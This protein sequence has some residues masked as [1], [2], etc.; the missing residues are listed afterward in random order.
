MQVK[1]KAWGDQVA[2]GLSCYR[3]G[4]VC[5]DCGVTWLLLRTLDDTREVKSY[6]RRLKH[7]H[8][9]PKT[10]LKKSFIFCNYRIDIAEG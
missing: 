7:T 9:E 4:N 3:D 5:K 1:G 6:E 10:A 8:R 2:V